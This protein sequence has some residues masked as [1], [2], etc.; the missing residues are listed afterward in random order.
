MLKFDYVE[1]CRRTVGDFYQSFSNVFTISLD[2]RNIKLG[3]SHKVVEIDESL[4]ARV[5]QK[6]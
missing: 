5:K 6:Q 1:A 2:K 3:G 4:F